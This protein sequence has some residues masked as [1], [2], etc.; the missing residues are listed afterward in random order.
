MVQWRVV[1]GNAQGSPSGRGS[2][3]KRISAPQLLGGERGVLARAECR[4]AQT[5]QVASV[6]A[7]C[8]EWSHDR[9]T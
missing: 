6:L 4:L 7:S 2:S 1:K 9:H 5:G 3:E 8:L